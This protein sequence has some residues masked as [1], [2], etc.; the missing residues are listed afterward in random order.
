MAMRQ[1]PPTYVLK[2][3]QAQDMDSE[4]Q[5]ITEQEAEVT[6]AKEERE[7]LMQED[8]SMVASRHQFILAHLEVL[9]QGQEAEQGEAWCV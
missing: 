2:D 1:I 3:Q 6:E 7:A 4:L 5:V 9:Y 8:T